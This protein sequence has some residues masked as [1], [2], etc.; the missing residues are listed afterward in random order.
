[1]S[2]GRLHGAHQVRVLTESGRE[3]ETAQAEDRFL[4]EEGADSSAALL[5]RLG[6][7]TDTVAL[8]SEA[9]VYRAREAEDDASRSAPGRR[10]P[11]WPPATLRIC[12]FSTTRWSGCSGAPRSRR[13]SPRNAA[14]SSGSS[15]T[16][17][18]TRTPTPPAGS[19]PD[20]GP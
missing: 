10:G 13:T 9:A 3:A 17:P 4:G 8:V 16:S 1:T 20:T 7:W 19:T 5:C 2:V 11:A 18:R 6:R 15:S 12:P 14:H